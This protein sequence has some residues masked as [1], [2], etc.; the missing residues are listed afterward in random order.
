MIH[1]YPTFIFIVSDLHEQGSLT[2]MLLP[3]ALL[4]AQNIPL[5]S[6]TF[7]RAEGGKPYVVGDQILS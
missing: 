1:Q 3:R 4:R 2:G 5:E 6:A 7:S